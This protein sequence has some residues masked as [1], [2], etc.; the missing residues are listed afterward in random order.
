M[1]LEEKVIDGVLHY[2]TTPSEEFQPYNLK[3]LT[4]R[5]VKLREKYERKPEETDFEW[6]KRVVYENTEGLI[7][8]D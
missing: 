4:H 3:Q 7:V 8:K 6:A 5:L 1:F 2:R